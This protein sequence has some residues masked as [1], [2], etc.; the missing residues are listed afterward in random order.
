MWGKLKRVGGNDTAPNLP[1]E[2]VLEG[3]GEIFIGRT[4]NV[5]KNKF[6]HEKQLPLPGSSWHDTNQLSFLL[7]SNRTLHFHR[8]A[9]S[10]FR[11]FYYPFPSLINSFS[12]IFILCRRSPGAYV[13]STH[14]SVGKKEGVPENGGS[15][16]TPYYIIDHS[17]NGTFCIR[18]EATDQ[19]PTPVGK[20]Q[21]DLYVGD[22][23]VLMFKH[24]SKCEYIFEA[25]EAVEGVAEDAQ[26]Q[27]KEIKCPP[28]GSSSGTGGT[29]N[30]VKVYKKEIQELQQENKQLKD[31]LEEEKQKCRVLEKEMKTVGVDKVKLEKDVGAKDE[32]IKVL[33]ST[34]SA[35]TARC[36]VFVNYLPPW[37]LPPLLLSLGLY[38]TT[39]VLTIYVDSGN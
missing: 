2:L 34:N 15:T 5:D 32:E 28:T 39:M 29:D 27:E 24:E 13:S 8:F 22:K 21:V 16:T 4:L 23:I 11:Y 31:L 1:D 30:V 9:F 38:I 33:H 36:Q 3:K 6:A 7:S 20:G 14:F 26:P 37:V 10:V 35:I 12:S 19:T 17:R 18:A 25:A